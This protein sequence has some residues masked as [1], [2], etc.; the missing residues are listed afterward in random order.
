MRASRIVVVALFV[1]AAHASI[2]SAQTCSA[3]YL[4]DQP[5]PTHGQEETRWQ[6]CW[7][8]ER[9]HGLIVTSARFR[10]Q[11]NREW[12]TVLKD[13][14]VAEIF[15]PYHD[16]QPRYLD[17]SFGFP[18]VALDATRDCPAEVGG[19]VLKGA[20]VCRELKDRGLAWKNDE[21]VR[22]GQAVTLWSA[23]DAGNYN[24]VIEWTFQDD[25]VMLGRVGA[26][27][28]N[29][30]SKPL[31]AHMHGP[32]WRLDL[33]INGSA[34][35][36][37]FVA[38]HTEPNAQASDT[39]RPVVKEGPI[40]WNAERFTSLHVHDMKLKNEN[41]KLSGYHLMPLRWGTPR[42]QEPFSRH[43][44]WVTVS[45]PLELLGDQL[46]AYTAQAE[47]LDRKDVVLWYYGG[48]HH[49][50]RDEDGRYEKE[51]WVGEA[52]IMWTGFMLKPHHLFSESPLG[53][54]ARPPGRQ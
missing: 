22:R 29:L 34:D 27:G 24:Y 12:V 38:E 28:R 3:E 11:P 53:A 8:V 18:S 52:H 35:D 16:G 43:D 31:E 46:P 41:G 7:A 42:H 54:G 13:A 20:S 5:F 33:D 23:L 40:D 32:I 44:F 21:R 9:G 48:V 4:I 51:D 49:L 10:T 1:L 26:T 15:V 36:A 6:V 45:N 37:V 30:P 50:V 25:G 47:P 19:Q 17:V 39:V 2:A 14:R